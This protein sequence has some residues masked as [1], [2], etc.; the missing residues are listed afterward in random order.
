MLGILVGLALFTFIYARGGS[1]FLDDP[2]ACLNC[3]IMRDQFDAW[4]HSTHKQ[5]TNFN[6]CHTPKSLFGKYLVKG[7]N[8]WNHSLA[9]TTGKFADPLRIRP[10]NRKIAI[11]NCIHCHQGVT[12]RMLDNAQGQQADCVACHDNVGHSTRN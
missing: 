9:F 5:V 7:V 8:G 2:Q 4:N 11:D 1:Y 6:S 3:H 12:S 10:F